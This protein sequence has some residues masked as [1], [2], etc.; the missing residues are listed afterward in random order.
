[1]KKTSA[2]WVFLAACW[3]LPAQ[4]G[5]GPLV[6]ARL[7]ELKTNPLVSPLPE[8][9]D[10]RAPIPTGWLA[11]ISWNVQG[12]ATDSAGSIRPAMVGAALRRL[13]AGTYRLL[14]A[15]EVANSAHA[16]VLQ[17]LL[18]GGAGRWRYAFFD[19]TDAQDNGL[20]YE[21]GL[22]VRNP[23]P[24]FV[25][26]EVS[27][28]GRIVTD[29]SRAVHPPLA[30][31]VA[32]GDFDFTLLTLHL[33]FADG[34]T[35]QSARELRV[36]LDFLDEYFRAPGHDPDVILCGDFNIPS[37]LS[38]QTGRDGITLD[39]LF[40]TDPRFQSG[41]RRFV[42]TVHEPTT[43]NRLGQPVSNYDHC[44]FSADALEELIQARRVQ[45]EILTDHPDDPEITLTSDHFPIV[46]FFRTRGEGIRRD[47]G[48]HPNIE[49]VTNGASFEPRI[50]SGAWVSI[51]GQDLATT[52]RIWREEEIR[53]G[54]LPAELDGVR[55]EFDGK[56][57][58]V[59]YVS[60]GQLNVQTPDGLPEGS[61]RVEVIHRGQRSGAFT[62]QVRRIAP[63][64]FR[65]PQE[66]G[67]FVAAVFAQL[68]HGHVVYVGRPEWFGGAVAARPAKPGERVLLF[69][70]GF[71]P[72]TPQVPAGRAFSGAAP[73][74]EP[75]QV[76]VGGVAATVEFAGLVGPGLYQFNL[77][78][79]QGVSPGDAAVVAE[80]AGVTTAPVALTVAP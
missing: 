63:A 15:Q 29:P 48:Y 4:D 58:W 43:R 18:P 45:P 79:P 75:V 76:T 54:V 80:I 73:L 56:P 19:T 61:V 24:L 23:V 25:T 62:A 50:S 32:V 34:D 5:A 22:L 36:I 41:E 52:T 37:R 39:A 59:Y 20:W 51:Y 74:T 70:T 57:A 49:A 78:V 6:E 12:G 7:A 31:H 30:A 17:G 13:F 3:T 55:V 21:R 27:A 2:A 65:F 38:G 26:R 47:L 28:T 14:A 40:D 66:G 44:V 11:L 60:P 46:A 68:E 10:D 64:F 1:M 33:T 16:A 42:V 77:V 72:T 67:R 69:G 71:G 35:R 8:V 53:D 9:P